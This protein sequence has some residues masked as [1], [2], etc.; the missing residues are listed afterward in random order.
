MEFPGRRILLLVSP[1]QLPC[2]PP[3][4]SRQGAPERFRPR[5]GRRRQQRVPPPVS[6][7]VCVSTSV[8]LRERVR[9][10]VSILVNQRMHTPTAMRLCQAYVAMLVYQA[11]S[12]STRAE[13]L[14]RVCNI[15]VYESCYFCT[16]YLCLICFYA[17]TSNL[18]LFTQSLATEL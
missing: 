16:L 18:F 4:L 1:T 15:L 13:G 8:C 2:L 14:Q 5:Q 17:F 11:C 12:Y 9:V 3:Q 6:V 7:C 10:G